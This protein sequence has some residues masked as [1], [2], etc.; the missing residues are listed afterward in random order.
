[1]SLYIPVKVRQVSIK[2]KFC[3]TSM[4]ASFLING[5]WTSPT[6]NGYTVTWNPN[7]PCFAW[8]RP[9]F[10]RFKPQNRGQTGSRQL[11]MLYGYTSYM[12][13]IQTRL[14]G[15]HK[16]STLL[17]A[18]GKPCVS[19]RRGVRFGWTSSSWFRSI[20]FGCRGS[21]WFP[22]AGQAEDYGDATELT[23]QL[24]QA[25]VSFFVCVIKCV[26]GQLPLRTIAPTKARTQGTWHVK[27]QI[28]DLSSFV[29]AR[30][31]VTL[32]PFFVGERYYT[33]KKY[34]NLNISCLKRDIWTKSPFLLGI[35]HLPF[36]E[37]IMLRW[38]GN[39]VN[40]F[41]LFSVRDKSMTGFHF[42]SPQ[43]FVQQP[44]FGS[45]V[46]AKYLWYCC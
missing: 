38:D 42:M 9:S 27:V 30:F 7:D 31:V 16:V 44:M 11:Y 29:T 24:Y 18:P 35:Q 12:I 6:F 33:L 5:K 23:Q 13:I 15:S 8:K 14:L 2:W 37:L 43:A 26:T 34:W 22:V 21:R 28:G 36:Q 10:G 3:Q 46:L 39:D 25:L 41:T 1:M 20:N 19:L 32:L 40:H 4:Y 45:W 17:R